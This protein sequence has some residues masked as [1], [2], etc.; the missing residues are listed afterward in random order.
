MAGPLSIKCPSC[1]EVF[2]LPVVG[3]A[4][5][6]PD[7]TEVELTVDRS[8]VYGHLRECPNQA[9]ALPRR[10][11]PDADLAG[12]IHLMLDNQAYVATGGSRACT[13]CGTVGDDCIPTGTPCCPACRD[14]NTHPA[15]QENVGTCAEWAVENGARQ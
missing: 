15:P 3:I 10:T 11:V 9:P 7:A 14:G 8:A 6:A 12:R 5:P 1:G 13:M 4:G 2:P